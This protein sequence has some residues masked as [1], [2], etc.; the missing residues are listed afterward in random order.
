MERKRD[1][2]REERRK[3]ESEAEYNEKELIP[4]GKGQF[5]N[6]DQFTK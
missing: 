1:G 3:M 6:S 5:G 4:T 2:R